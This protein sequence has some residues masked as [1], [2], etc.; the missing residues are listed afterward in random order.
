MFKRMRYQQGC[1]ARERRS[2]GPDVW[3]FRWRELNPNGQRINRKLVVGTVEYAVRAAAQKAVDALRLH[4]NKETPRSV[5]QPL[6][7]EQL[8]ALSEN[9]TDGEQSQESIFNQGCIQVLPRQLGPS[10]MAVL[11]TFSG[12]DGRRRGVAG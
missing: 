5:F 1:V 8:I 7:C 2:H 6:T 9:G 4:I 12:E 11:S 3:I 10:A